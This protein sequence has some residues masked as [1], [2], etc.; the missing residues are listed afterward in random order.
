[1]NFLAE[2]LGNRQRHDFQVHLACRSLVFLLG[3]LCKVEANEETLLSFLPLHGGLER[4]EVG[5]SGFVLLLHLNREPAVVFSEEVVSGA[6]LL[7]LCCSVDS[8]VDTHVSNLRAVCDG[9]TACDNR[10][11]S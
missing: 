7:N 9:L 1:M 4:A 2:N 8:S 6:F 5:P 11:Q 3:V 10:V